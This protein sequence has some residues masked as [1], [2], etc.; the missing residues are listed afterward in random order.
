[1]GRPRE[2]N[3]EAALEQAMQT[4]WARGYEATSLHDLISAMGISK[5]SFYDTFGSKHELF[6]ATMDHYNETVASRHIAELIE[7]APNVKA[8]IAEV[9][10][11]TIDDMLADGEKRGCFINSCAIE[12]APHDPA[13]AARVAVGMVNIE[14]GFIGAIQRAQKSGEIAAGRDP[15]ALARYLTSSLNGLIVMAKTNPNRTALTEIADITLGA[16]E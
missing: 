15:R 12:T 14:D 5:S 6:L 13:A 3:T 7:A 16:L 10:N 4:F 1:M 9:F 8:G 2:F 11:T